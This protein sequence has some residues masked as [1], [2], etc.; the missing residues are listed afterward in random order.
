M[1][2]TGYPVIPN[3]LLKS[4]TNEKLPIDDREMLRQ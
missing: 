1:S 2:F 4:D 3:K